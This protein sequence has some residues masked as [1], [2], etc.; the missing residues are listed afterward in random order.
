MIIT[1]LLFLDDNL[2]AFYVDILGILMCFSAGNLM[3]LSFMSVS[4][5][6]K[7]TWNSELIFEFSHICDLGVPGELMEAIVIHVWSRQRLCR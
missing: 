7:F 4:S 1:H 2:I 5:L 3:I 6:H